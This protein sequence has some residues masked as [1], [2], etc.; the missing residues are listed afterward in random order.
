MKSGK[1]VALSLALACSKSSARND[2]AVSAIPNGD[3][4]ERIVG[5]LPDGAVLGHHF[6][7][8]RRAKRMTFGRTPPDSSSVKQITDSAAV[9]NANARLDSLFA[10]F[11]TASSKDAKQTPTASIGVV[12]VHSTSIGNDPARVKL[13]KGAGIYAVIPTDAESCGADVNV[14]PVVFFFDSSWRYL[15]N[16]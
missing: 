3:E 13:Y 9:A 2:G 8:D 10:T 14:A 6:A 15:G 4:C 7:D 1:I 12:T 5:P 11:G 16:R